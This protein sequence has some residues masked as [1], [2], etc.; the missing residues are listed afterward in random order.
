MTFFSDK[1]VSE[2]RLFVPEAATLL[3][4]QLL[5]GISVE[6]GA[7]PNEWIVQSKRTQN[8]SVLLLVFGEFG[9]YELS[10]EE[11]TAYLEISEKEERVVRNFLKSCVTTI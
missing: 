3:K 1:E 7:R 6:E 5:I 9:I 8:S 2:A 10:V 11:T 4:D